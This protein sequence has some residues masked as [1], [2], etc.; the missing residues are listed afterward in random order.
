MSKL[1]S[2][3]AYQGAKQR[4]A[5]EIVDYIYKFVPYTPETKY[6]DL[7][8]GSGAITVELLNR[9]V[10]PEQIVMCDKSSWGTFWAAIGVGTYDLNTFYKYSKAVPRDKALIQSFM[11]TLAQTDASIDEPYKYIL[12][13]ASAFGGKQIWRD[14]NKWMNTFFR[15]YWQPTETSTRRS[16]VNPMQ[17]MIDVLERRV[18]NLVNSCKGLTCYRCDVFE[19]KTVIDNDSAD[20]VIYIDPPYKKTTGY[21]FDFDYMNFITR[22]RR[23][24]P[25]F[26]SEKEPISLEAFKLNFEGAKGGISG[27]KKSKNAEYLSVF[28]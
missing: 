21:G 18:A 24:A 9:G 3:C 6:Y 22:L 27:V 28:R 12:L 11:V 25:I 13:Q 5:S 10:R 2:P 16:P 4:V 17:P 7:C 26:V 1:V 8:C 23:T 14:G 19:M 20:K 15:N